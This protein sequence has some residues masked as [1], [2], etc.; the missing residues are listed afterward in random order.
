M[1]LKGR[2]FCGSVSYQLN[3]DGEP[4]FE[5]L[6]HCSHCQ[7]WSG[8]AFVSAMLVPKE[9][10]KLEGEIQYF[11][12]KGGSGHDLKRGFCPKCGGHIL[13]WTTK[14]PNGVMIMAGSLDDPS[15]FRPTMNIFCRS[16]QEHMWHLGALK[17]F[18]GAPTPSG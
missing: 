4:I 15:A 14:R 12:H 10:L 18:D 2:C 13:L 6:C 8:T 9:A 5:A 11:E 7:R 1:H 16:A 3:F 17:Q